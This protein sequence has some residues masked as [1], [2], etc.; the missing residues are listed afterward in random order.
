MWGV[1]AALGLLG[2]QADTAAKP[3]AAPETTSTTERPNTVRDEAIRSA[4]T[5][6]ST[7]RATLPPTTVRPADYPLGTTLTVTPGDHKITVYTYRGSVTSDNRFIQPKA[8]FNFS[9]IDVQHCAGPGGDRFGLN[10]FDWELAMPDNTRLRAG[11]NVTEP[12]LASSPL[13]GGDCIRGW[14]SFEVPISGTPSHVV[15]N[16]VST[17]AAKWRVG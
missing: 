2:C 13:A 6:P 4:A 1:A 11:S 16:S 10:R 3:E 15:Y 12:Q 17:G 14:V 5:A 9:S 7:T 8:G